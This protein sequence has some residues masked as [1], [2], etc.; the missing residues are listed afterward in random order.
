MRT[1]R[2]QTTMTK[3][4]GSFATILVAAMAA[5]MLTRPLPAMA[6]GPAGVDE[7]VNAALK[8]LYASEPVAKM[9]GEKAKAVLVF[10]TIVK[11]GFI[12]GGQYGEGALLKEGTIVGHYNSVAAS[13]GLQA[14]A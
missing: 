4:T 11:A 6:A 3:C 7:D 12:I 9:I 10:P 8:K 14:G 1:T 2:K 13:Y 5:T